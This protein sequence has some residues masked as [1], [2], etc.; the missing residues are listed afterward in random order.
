MVEIRFHGRGGQGAVIAS[1]ILAMA[2]F[3]EGKYVQSFPLFGVERRGAPV[4]AFTR[5]DDRPVRMKC[6]I[7]TPDCIIVL[8]PTLTRTVDI[9]AGLKKGGYILINSD[10][11]PEEYRE[12]YQGFKIAT[13]DADSI[14]REF[15]LGS[16]TSPI[17]N[18]VILGAF[19]A[20]TKLV[21][22]ESIQDGIRKEIPVKTEAN[23]DAARKA[24][25]NIK[26]LK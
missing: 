7:Y 20:Q 10:S 2:F 4:A 15:R 3:E 24:Y 9:T 6:N 13:I 16:A 21:R 17:I 11:S 14:A 26:I 25:E 8:D 22:L 5:V 18:T 12:K 19:A 23:C 1:K